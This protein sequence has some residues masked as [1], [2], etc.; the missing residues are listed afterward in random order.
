MANMHFWRSKQ[1]RTISWVQG[2]LCSITI[3]LSWGAGMTSTLAAQKITIRLG[4]FQQAIAIADIEAFAK[5]GKLPENLQL[6][7]PFL[8]P[9]FQELLNRRVQVDPALA[10][11]FFDDLVRSPQGQQLIS[12]LGVAIPGSTV[13]GLQGALNLSLRQVNGLSVLGFLRA[14]PEENVTLDATKAIQIAV[15][16]NSNYLQSQALGTLLERDLLVK[17]T[18]NFQPSF[19]P[20]AIGKEAVQQQTLTLQDKQRKRSIPVDIYWSQGHTQAPLVVISPGLGANRKF[21]SY[22]AG[23]LASYGFTVAAMEHPDSNINGSIYQASTPTNLAQILAPTEFID[24]PKDISFLLDEL[25]KLNNQSGTLQG[26]FN[27]DKVTVIG[28]SLGGYTALAL[29]GPEVDLEAVRQFCQNSLSINESPGDWLQ[30][31]AAPLKEKKLQLKDPRVTSAIAFNPVVGNLFGKTGLNKINNPVLILTSTEDSLTPSLKHQIAP[32]NQLQSSKYLLTA[33]G[34]THLSISDPS[35]SAST[36]TTI[37]PEKRGSETN[38]L[39]QLVRGVTLAFVKQSTPEAKIYQPFLTPAYAQSLS[40]PELPLR[41]NSDLPR[42]I[43]PWLGFVVDQL[44]K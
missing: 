36:A 8:T 31:A 1:Q 44:T 38:S 18:T 16:F 23:H 4:P 19:D 30:C 5:T 3:A 10:D 13:E 22:L 40:K 25:A 33:I 26:K 12:S 27:T 20:A 6:F 39:R 29:L 21:L 32:F 15:E 9:Q 35:Y 2:L 28:H 11:K 14:Y 43:K 37:F 17:N 42:N 41:L 24:R 34:G 7:R